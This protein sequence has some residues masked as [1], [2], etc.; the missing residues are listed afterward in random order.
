MTQIR[1][2]MVLAAGLG[3]R[4]RPLTDALPKPLLTL[5]DRT[6]LDH[7][8]DRLLAAGVEQ[9]VVNCHWQADMLIAHVAA[10]T[11]GPRIVIQREETLL[12]TGGAV[13]KALPHFGAD[14]F[15]VVNG[16]TFWLDGPHPAL[17]RLAGSWDADEADAVLL[18]H[19]TFQVSAEVGAGDFSLDS[20]GKVIR[21]AELQI[22]PYVYT[23][24]QII[25]HR[26]CR[27]VAPNGGVFGASRFWE[28][29]LER[30]R[31]RGVVHDGL[32]FHLSTPPDLAEA[33]WVLHQRQV[34]ETR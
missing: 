6:L 16:D 20:L 30:E 18:L 29:A 34:G 22:V 11:E 10:R 15:F 27:S 28:A 25:D 9:V 1:N 24:V 21:R 23:G 17:D 19:R 12:G 26:L 31:L 4:M 32:W 7:A 13:L 8:L 5:G 3:T 2:A 14:P 33:D